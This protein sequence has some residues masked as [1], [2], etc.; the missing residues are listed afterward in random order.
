[1]CSSDLALRVLAEERGVKLK[2]FL[3][4]F[5][6]ACTGNPVSVPLFDAMAL[7]GRDLV[8]HRMRHALTQLGWPTNAEREAWDKLSRAEEPAEEA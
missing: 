5:Y 1:V 2:D 7:L 8:R 3:R 6:V 4:P